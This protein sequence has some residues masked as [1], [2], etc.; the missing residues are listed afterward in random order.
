MNL[1]ETRDIF[2][3]SR[4]VPGNPGQLVTLHTRRISTSSFYDLCIKIRNNTQFANFSFSSMDI[5]EVL[6]LLIFR[7]ATLGYLRSAACCV[8]DARH[9][10]LDPRLVHL[11]DGVIRNL[12][13]ELKL[14]L[15]SRQSNFHLHYD[16]LVNPASTF[17][18]YRTFILF[19]QFK[20]NETKVILI[21]QCPFLW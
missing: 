5:A 8:T 18:Y 6:T 7:F 9:I 17:T 4:T 16:F 1:A 3:H 11:T 21:I 2:P 20:F 15:F 14:L 19:H 10:F 13:F 12:R